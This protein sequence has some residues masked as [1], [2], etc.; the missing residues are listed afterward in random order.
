MLNS[1]TVLKSFVQDSLCDSPEVQLF[2]GELFFDDTSCF[3]SRSQHILLGGEVVWLA[4]SL[5]F[6]EVADNGR[7]NRNQ[8]SDMK[9]L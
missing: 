8:A 5:H 7:T 3:D 1:I 4:D 6:I 9:P 2:A